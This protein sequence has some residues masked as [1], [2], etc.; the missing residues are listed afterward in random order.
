MYLYIFVWSLPLRNIFN[1]ESFA[2]TT[3]LRH[4]DTVAISSYEERFHQ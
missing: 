2:M 1:Y 3:E 4:F